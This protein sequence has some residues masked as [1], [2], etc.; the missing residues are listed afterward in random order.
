MPEQEVYVHQRE[1]IHVCV[2]VMVVYIDL[3]GQ[4]LRCATA[5]LITCIF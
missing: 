2:A 5:V 4:T 1:C 3:V